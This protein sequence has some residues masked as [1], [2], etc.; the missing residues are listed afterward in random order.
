MRLE[1]LLPFKQF[2]T[3]TL[4]FLHFTCIMHVLN[5]NFEVMFSFIWLHTLWA[6]ELRL[7]VDQDAMSQRLQSK[8]NWDMFKSYQSFFNLTDTQYIYIISN[9]LWLYNNVPWS[10]K[11]NKR[12]SSKKS[13]RKGAGHLHFYLKWVILNS[14]I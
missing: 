7:T 10:I 3:S 4:E 14:Y 9:N 13:W 2:A 1:W 6:E 8:L 11:P 5:V 12:I